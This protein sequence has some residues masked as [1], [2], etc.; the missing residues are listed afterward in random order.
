[1]VIALLSFSR[2]LAGI[3]DHI[4]YISINNQQ[5]MN[6]TTII[7]LYPNEYYEKLCYHPFVFNLDRY[8][9]SC[10]TLNDLFN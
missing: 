7:N 1:M 4:T 6:Q 2:F 8:L 3:V 9:G 10:N 5:H